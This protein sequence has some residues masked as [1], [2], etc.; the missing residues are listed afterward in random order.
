MIGR[1]QSC[2]AEVEE[3]LSDCMRTD[4]GIRLNAMKENAEGSVLFDFCFATYAAEKMPNEFSF[5]LR[6]G[7]LKSYR[8]VCECCFLPKW[9]RGPL[10]I[11]FLCFRRIPEGSLL[12]TLK[13]YS[14]FLLK[15]TSWG[16]RASLMNL[17]KAF[18]MMPWK[19]KRWK[20][21]RI[22][23]G[24]RAVG[25]MYHDCTR[26]KLTLMTGMEKVLI[27]LLNF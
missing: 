15:H 1:S 7:M 12:V 20:F 26:G 24:G 18:P 27:D 17:W 14:D 21:L 4:T 23:I 6:C 10:R 8:T 2:V 13:I 3:I 9:C 16:K 25:R 5:C 11:F 19:G 22:W